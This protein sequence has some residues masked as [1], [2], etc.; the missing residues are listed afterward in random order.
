MNMQYLA[1]YDGY[2]MMD[3]YGWGWGLLM[4]LFWA[5]VIIAI[6]ILLVRGLSQNDQKSKDDNSLSIAKNRYAKGEITKKEFE[7]LKKDLSSK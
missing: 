4:M 5:L 1:H 3:G 6:V 7:Q 2:F